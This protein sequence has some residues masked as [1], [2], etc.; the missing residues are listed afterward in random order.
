MQYNVTCNHR[1]KGGNNAEGVGSDFSRQGRPI[2]AEMWDIRFEELVQF[3]GRAGDCL[4][5]KNETNPLYVWVTTQRKQFQLLK[6]RKHS[7]I[8]LARIARLDSIG[9]AWRVGKD[10]S[11]LSQR[12]KGWKRRFEEFKQYLHDHGGCYPATTKGKATSLGVW[13]MTQ[14]TQYRKEEKSALKQWQIQMHFLCLRNC[15]L[16]VRAHLL[17]FYSTPPSICCCCCYC[18]CWVLSSPHRQYSPFLQPQTCD[19][20]LH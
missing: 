16:P 20:F 5:P 6:S 15:V 12:Q 10:P 8:T 14:R 3:K 19:L 9:F 18:F 4:V 7:H 2:L 1:R 13:M 17:R 11:A